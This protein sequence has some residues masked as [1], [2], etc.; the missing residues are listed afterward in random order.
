MMKFN[1]TIK[2]N[3]STQVGIAGLVATVATLTAVTSLYRR[4]RSR[5][6]PSSTKEESTTSTSTTTTTDIPDEVL[7]C[8]WLEELEL[9]IMLAKQAG[10]NMIEYLESK[11]TSTES[12]FDLGIETKSGKADFCT[13][14]DIENEKLIIDG[15]KQKYPTHSIIGEESVGT[16]GIPPLT[17]NTWIIDP[18]DGTTNFSSGIHS[19]TCVSIAYVENKRPVVGVIY[20]PGT[21]ELYV[22][23][24]GYGAYRNSCRIRQ[25]SDASTKSL[26]DAV[27][28][29][30]FGY[31]RDSKSVETIITGLR[32]VIE[33]GCPRAIRQF[34]SGCLDLCMV[35]SGRIDIVYAGL[36]NEG[37]KPWDYAAGLVLCEE[38][39][40]I[41]ESIDQNNDEEGFDLYS[42]SVICGVSRELVDE[43]RLILSFF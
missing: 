40:C 35:A 27:V 26:Q 39:G 43:L 36:A 23:V 31:S 38:A 14:V 2:F 20:A 3:S 6:S 19:M 17:E 13:S 18:I 22:G 21:Q 42:S 24:K 32:K 15:I 30:E 12:L 37:W 16:G 41:M 7:E 11:G 4:A 8:P 34:G 33:S 28:C 25:T 5:Q 9:G 1:S 10:S 29:V